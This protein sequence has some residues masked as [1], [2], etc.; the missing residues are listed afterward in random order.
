MAI[1]I[2]TREK[3]MLAAAAAVVL[4]FALDFFAFRPMEK[5]L[6]DRRV[7]LKEIEEKMSTTVN[8]IPELKALRTRVEEKAAFLATAKDKIVGREQ[9][10]FFLNH[11]AS[12]SGRLKLEINSLTFPKAG[13][14]SGGKPGPPE[15]EA[16]GPGPTFKKVKAQ[17]NLTGSYEG[18]REYLSRVEQLPLFMELDEI[19]IEGNREGLPKVVLSLRPGFL[20]RAEEKL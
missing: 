12:E 4:Y 7:R 15:K 6:K 20:M 5:Q 1:N 14:P 13:E 19:Q 16:K 17:I 8:T 11:L 2:K 9:V 18:I 10:R 3:I